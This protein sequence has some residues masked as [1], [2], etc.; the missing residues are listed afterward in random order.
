LT[1]H[2]GR[3]SVI[4][5]YCIEMAPASAAYATN[6]LSVNAIQRRPASTSG[7]GIGS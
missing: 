4:T 3:G 7:S 6:G 1:V 5:Q 2:S